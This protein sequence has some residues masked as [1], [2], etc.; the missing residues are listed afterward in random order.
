L[1][2]LAAFGGSHEVADLAERERHSK[3]EY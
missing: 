2:N 1:G 3:T